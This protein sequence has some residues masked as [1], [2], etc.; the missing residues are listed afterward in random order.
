MTPA[1]IFNLHLGLGYV[2]WL[3]CFFAYAWPRLREMDS[4]RANR[5]IAALHMFRF[6]GLVLVLPGVVGT[7]LPREFAV[8]AAYGD[9]AT[10]ILATLAFVSISK[11]LLFGILT[12]AFNVVGFLDVLIDYWH[13]ATENLPALSGELGSAYIIPIVYV[14]ILMITHVA[15]FY[16]LFHNRKRATAGAAIHRMN[17][18]SD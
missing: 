13:G 4:V 18:G 2:P 10:A 11:P 5:A 15:A 8:V 7:A 1:M 12:L 3:L 16:L 14:P 17:L 6:F 9:L